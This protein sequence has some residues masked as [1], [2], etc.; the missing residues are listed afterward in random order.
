MQRG[1]LS[2]F[3]D[4]LQQFIDFSLQADIIDE[5]FDL[6][7]RDVSQRGGFGIVMGKI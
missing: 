6:L 4:V 1:S 2:V 5:V 7:K 3:V